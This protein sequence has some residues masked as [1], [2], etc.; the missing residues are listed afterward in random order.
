ML[1]HMRNI[2]VS[3]YPDPIVPLKFSAARKGGKGR[4]GGQG[5]HGTSGGRGG[6]SSSSSR[7]SGGRRRVDGKEG[8]SQGLGGK[9]RK[10]KASR[11]QRGDDF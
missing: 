9:A 5:S 2:P 11:L 10:F 1:R 6:S 4:G 3:V 7:G 8:S